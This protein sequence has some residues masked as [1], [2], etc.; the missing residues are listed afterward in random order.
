MDKE[1]HDTLFEINGEDFSKFF[2]SLAETCDVEGQRILDEK[3]LERAKAIR[4]AVIKA[5]DELQ[6]NN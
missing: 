2:P 1:N 3:L 6:K 4:E 5:C